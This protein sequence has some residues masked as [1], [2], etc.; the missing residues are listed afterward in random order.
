VRNVA[1][2][3]RHILRSTPQE[4]LQTRRSLSIWDK[5]LT[6][7]VGNTYTRTHKTCCDL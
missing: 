7:Y 5:A 3:I 6:S 4:S 1:S 2:K